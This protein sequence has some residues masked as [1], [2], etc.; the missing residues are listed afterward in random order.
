MRTGK[1]V[2]GAPH[3]SRQSQDGKSATTKEATDTYMFAL[4]SNEFFASIVER[5]PVGTQRARPWPVREVR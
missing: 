4:P 1:S 2:N 3:L 5:T